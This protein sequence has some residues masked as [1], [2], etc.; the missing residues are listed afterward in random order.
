MLRTIF[1]AFRVFSF[2]F[3]LASWW[4]TIVSGAK[5]TWNAYTRIKSFVM[6]KTEKKK[7]GK[8]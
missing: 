2:V 6:R 3:S 1:S 8:E 5:W 7:T 4:K